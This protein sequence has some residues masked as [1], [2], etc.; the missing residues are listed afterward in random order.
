MPRVLVVNDILE[1]MVPTID[2]L[3]DSGVDVELARTSQ[4]ALEAL[5][6]RQ[7]DAVVSDIDRDN[8]P[9]EG[10][11]FLQRM[12][13]LGYS[14]PVVFAVARLDE[15]LGTPDGAAAICN[16]HEDITRATLRVVTR[17]DIIHIGSQLAT[18]VADDPELIYDL[19]PD[20]FEVLVCDRLF[21]MGFEPKRVGSVYQADGGVDIF[22]WPRTSNA[23]PFL[24]AAQVKHHKRPT[25]KEG[26][27]NIQ[28]FAGAI[29]VHPVNAAMYITNT[30]FSPNARWYAEKHAQLLRLRD[31]VDIKRWLRNDFSGNEEWREIPKEIE[32][33]PGMVVK[34]RK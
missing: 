25:I 33:F 12:R 16:N 2:A 6:T 10:I 28:Q 11:Q 1:S 17:I 20:Q 22:F 18:L 13:S 26:M 5:R 7:F 31:F 32:V 9:D 19:S 21:A 24:G 34:L 3:Q 14:H 23:F 29:D 4:A 27:P 15:S 8:V 30:S